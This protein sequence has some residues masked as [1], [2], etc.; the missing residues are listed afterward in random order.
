MAL[1][2]VFAGM[3]L[4]ADL[5]AD[6]AKA[7]V[8]GLDYDSRRVE[9]GFLFFAFEGQHADGRRF[10]AS[11]IERGAVAVVSQSG[12]PAAFSGN[13][14]EVEHGRRALAVAARN[15]YG[16]PDERIAVTGITGTNGKTT[17]CYLVDAV[18]RAA[19]KTTALVGTIEYHL[20]PRVIPAVNTTPESLD[21]VRMLAELEAIGGSHA[22]MEVS[23]H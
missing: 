19:N 8:R 1:G 21:L 11:A 9:N 14:I 17:T 3:S 12:R 16:K 13:W 23:S 6:L 22:T 20:G 10:A 4:K 7:Q 2:G 5:P 18:L 15:F